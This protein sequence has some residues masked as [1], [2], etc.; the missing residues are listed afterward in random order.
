MTRF[1]PPPEAPAGGDIDAVA[2]KAAGGVGPGGEACR[3]RA[4]EINGGPGVEEGPAGE[5][6]LT[7]TACPRCAVR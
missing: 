5:R 3:R 7:G 4:G 2:G 1:R 6:E